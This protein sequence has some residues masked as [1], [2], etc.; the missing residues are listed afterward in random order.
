MSAAC[1]GI[2]QILLWLCL[3]LRLLCF[4]RST[5]PLLLLPLRTLRF[6]E[7]QILS[8]AAVLLFPRKRGRNVYTGSNCLGWYVGSIVPREVLLPSCLRLVLVVREVVSLFLRI[9]GCL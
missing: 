2:P 7:L 5:V 6:G 3:V 4:Y 9:L 1:P 8:R